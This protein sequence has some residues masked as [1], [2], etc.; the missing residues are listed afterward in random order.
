MIQIKVVVGWLCL[1]MLGLFSHQL[2]PAAAPVTDAVPEAR[3]REAIAPALKLIEHSSAV[4]LRE[5]ECFSCHHQ[6]MSIMTLTLAR[7]Y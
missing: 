6:A 1:L 5:R 3:L 4:Y 7:Q 2:V